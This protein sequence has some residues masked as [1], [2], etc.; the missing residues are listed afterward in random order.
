M[1]HIIPPSCRIVGPP[2]PPPPEENWHQ[3]RKRTRHWRHGVVQF[4]SLLLG[5]RYITYID[6]YVYDV[7]LHSKHFNLIS[8]HR[9][10][11]LVADDFSFSSPFQPLQGPSYSGAGLRKKCPKIHGFSVLFGESRITRQ[12]PRFFR[13]FWGESFGRSVAD[14]E[15]ELLAQTETPP[16]MS[17][18]VNMLEKWWCEL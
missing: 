6:A 13:Y 17:P 15:A 5:K 18:E 10:L 12:I 14:L 1:N 7:F 8:R 16:W 11:S 2:P 4:H 3:V 9:I